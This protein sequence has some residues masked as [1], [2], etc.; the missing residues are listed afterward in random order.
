[1]TRPLLP[2]RAGALV[3]IGVGGLAMLGSANLGMGSM[4]DPGPGLWPMVASLGLLTCSVAYLVRPDRNAAEP[5]GRE[6]TVVL[7]GT[8]SVVLYAVLFER[9]G[10][11]IPSVL[12]LVLWLRGFGQE[13]WRTS[14]A[15]A[16]AA[17]AAVYA[18]FIV[19]LGVSL[20]HLI[21]F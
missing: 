18:V 5:I 10:F 9:I 13:S 19:A 3:L 6:A 21:A 4:A 20:P 17:T 1:M 7:L 15:V 16:L 12:L 2:T 11:E 14:V 8:L